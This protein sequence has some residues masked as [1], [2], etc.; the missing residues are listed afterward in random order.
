MTTLSFSSTDEEQPKLCTVS[1]AT[2][3]SR[4]VW[5]VN[6]I[7]P[8]AVS[9]DKI[10]T[11]AQGTFIAVGTTVAMPFLMAGMVAALPAE[12]TLAAS[13]LSV[14]LTTAEAAAS[15]GA[16][17]TTACIVF[18]EDADTLGMDAVEGEGNETQVYNKRPLCASRS[19]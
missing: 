7:L 15:V 16:I 10:K 5:S 3:D 2:D 14:G 11:F 4:E 17:G 8:R 19:W 9:S 1:N 6:A 18:R 13:I 12:A